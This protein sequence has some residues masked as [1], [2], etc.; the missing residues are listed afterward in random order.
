MYYEK[1][2]E[3]NSRLSFIAG[4]T[5]GIAAGAFL[6]KSSGGTKRLAKAFGDISQTASSIKSDL[7]KLSF[8]ELD[9]KNISRIA[10][11]RV[12]N[13][14][15]TLKMAMRSNTIQDID[16]T[17]GLFAAIRDFDSFKKRSSRIDDKI[18][19]NVL[20]DEVSKIVQREYKNESREFFEQ[21][22]IMA[23]DVLERKQQYFETVEGSYMHAIKEE[24]RQRT[25]GGIFDGQ[26]EKLASIFEEAINNSEEIL[27]GVQHE[28]DTVLHNQLEK[29]YK[30]AILE[31]Y[32]KDTDFFKN[33]LDRAAEV[34]DFLKAVEDGVIENNSEIEEIT[35]ILSELVESDERFGTLKV[36]AKS[37]RISPQNEMYSLKSVNDIA[38][39][40][41]EEV[42]DTIPGKLFGVR[43]HLSNKNVPDFHYFGQGTFDSVLAAHTGSKTGL[44]KNDHFMIGSNVFE[45]SD[46]KLTKLEDVNIKLIGGKHGPMASLI[47]TMA[48]NTY[49]NPVENK[50]LRA[51]DIGTKGELEI[52]EKLSIVKKLNPDSDWIP[53]VVKRLTDD[54]YDNPFYDEKL[55]SGF[56]KDIKLVNKMYN[57]QTFAPDIK[58]ITALKESVE[59]GNVKALLAALESKN[60]SAAILENPNI[61]TDNFINKDLK[62][63][64]NKYKYNKQTID[65]VIHI[66]DMNGSFMGGKNILDY[67]KMITREVF[68]EAMLKEAQIRRN[69]SIGAYSIISSI[70]KDLN[71]S[72]A[73]K[74]NAA[75][76][77]NW[78]ILQ[79]EGDLFASSSHKQI[80]ALKKFEQVD[81][82]NQLLKVKRGN[83]Q[84]QAFLEQFQNGIK[85]FAKENSSAF[86]T[87]Y[88]RNNRPHKPYKSNDFIAINKSTSVLDIIRSLNDEQKLKST[89]KSFGKQLYAGRDNM[90]EVTTAT[91]I[92]FH[93]LNRL[94]TPLE[95]VGLGFSKESTKSVGNLALNIGL[96]RILPV[97]AA[98]YTLSYLNY[99]SENFTGTSLTEAFENVKANFILGTKTITDP[100]SHGN[101][102]SRYYNPIAQYWGGDYKDKDEYLE[103]LEY[104][105]DP[106]RKGRFW[107]FG[108]SAE[109]RG[110]KVA[111]WKPNSLRMAHSNYYDIAVYGSSEE[112][113]KHSLMPSLRHPLS[114]LRF[115][116]NPY[117]LEQKHYEDRPYP[118]TG[119]LFTEGTPWGAVLNPTIGELIKPQRKMHQ[120]EM[121]GTLTDVRTLIAQRNEEIRRKSAE[122]SM[123][124]LDNSGFT[125][126]SFNPNSMPSMS[127]A[128]FSINISDGRV[129]DAG[130]EGQSYANSLSTIDM[131][132]IPIEAAIGAG[133]NGTSYISVGSGDSNTANTA[134]S[135]LG[136]TRL[137][138]LGNST[139]AIST[140]TANDII[141]NVN[142]SIFAKA[143][144]RSGS[145][146]VNEVGNLHTNPFRDAAERQKTSYLE[147]MISNESKSEYVNDLLYSATQL[148]GMYGFLGGQ[149]LPESKKYKL[150]RA[151]MNSFSN[152]FWDSSI[153]GLGDD[154]MEIA[155]RFFPHADHSVEQINNIRNTMPEWM[156][157]RFQLG[158]P[159]N[160]VPLGEARLPGAGY[161]SLNKLHSDK[162]GRYGAFDR[163]KI[164]ADIAPNTEE[165]KTWKKIAKLEVKDPFLVR[166]MEQ[167]EKRVK[168]QTK[169]HD[170]Y[171]YKF[172]TRGLEEHSAII[173]EVTNTGKFTIVGSEQQFS[174]AGIKPLSDKENGSYVHQYL[175]PGMMV[176]LKYED[177]EYRK[178]DKDGNISAL[179]F[180][181]GQNVS[182]QMF[183]D[184]TGKEKSEKETLADEYFALSDS[185]ISMGHFWEA[186]GH[187]PIPYIHNKYLRIDSPMEAYKKEQIYGTPYATWDH[188]IKGFVMPVFQE[189]WGRGIAYQAL[190]L[191]TMVF[192]NMAR[193]KG[194]SDGVQ[195]LAH[196]AF[197]LTNPGGFAGGVIG[198]I[199]RMT[200]SSHASRIGW[201]SKN[202]ANIGAIVGV[203]GYAM[204][205]LENP[206][207]SAGNFAVAGLAA[208]NQLKIDG[209]NGAKG[210]LI[211]AAVGLGLSAI[212]N[213]EFSLNK[214]GEKYIPKDTKKK[215]EIEEYFDRLEYLKYNS[216]YEKAARIAKRKEGVDVAK[217]INSFEYNRD[218]NVDKIRKL[219]ER[220]LKI[221]KTVL[222]VNMRDSLVATLDSQIY[223][224]QTPEQYFQMGE[225]T[226][227]ALAYKK[228]AD[229]TIYGLN[230]YSSTA[231]VLRALPK[232]DRDFFLEFAK[233]KDPKARKKIL[234]YVSPYKQKALKIMWGEDI[235]SNEQ[236]SNYEYFNQHHLPGLSWAG[237]NP[238]VDLD[239]VKMK[240]IENEG[241]L[242]SDFG[243]Y[244]SQK[245]EPAYMYSPEIKDM[246]SPTSTLAIQK[247]LLGL[248]N[249]LGLQNVEVSVD[250]MQGEGFNVIS[251]ITR[252]ASYNLQEKVRTTLE[253]IF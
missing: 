251:N 214:L 65:Q 146:V 240:T 159:Y 112:K 99:E 7:S 204:A 163:Y 82:I 68:K 11:E 34:N 84:E 37:L 21:A 207:L 3:R 218:K 10:K 206:L 71:V 187:M 28:Y 172:L 6:L 9:A 180:S 144:Q 59:N 161:E 248:L 126:M 89:M 100:L 247:D 13:D 118:V 217:I 167:I 227:A 246:N 5:A 115:L 160:K 192:S 62:T 224:L 2:E 54:T 181:D 42:A 117:W 199:P 78:S 136:L 45:Y 122:R 158:D 169:E 171:S 174:L 230:E 53:N 4:A 55:M 128:V 233:E 191:S 15:S 77:L 156:P 127:E 231:D 149:I 51:L 173:E 43:S 86:E 239:N 116:S 194:M 17:K 63:L 60:P 177:N 236:E 49:Y 203:T 252:I 234:K 124:R 152:K 229:T 87:M 166:Q 16:Q 195:T 106:V 176:T 102:A 41:A 107:S 157:S 164:L 108:S 209:I 182:R 205:N 23:T 29:E 142:S 198:A 213:P 113:W 69:E 129:T 183:R 196:T 150:E 193:S 140:G 110:G 222:D 197:A 133:E 73:E 52:K 184:R 243:M 20:I 121:A 31:K 48:G 35:Q 249:G 103:Y 245:G 109:F 154:V 151:N 47:N 226:K 238:Q 22:H 147:S 38:N 92:P 14:D 40:F 220:K 32:S 139:G 221:Q 39:L 123:V 244:E 26:E 201:N 85:T 12:L 119:K 235:A 134:N 25:E 148:S 98:G 241:M 74:K 145:S 190:G 155:R 237:W 46:G 225:Y 165:Y 44:L 212:K 232:Y 67:N 24:F 219:N 175:K 242:L 104:G 215:W 76:L 228:A 111:Y 18:K 141:R 189:A 130:F 36:D 216:L 200:L 81:K 188:P 120:R 30:D 75:N 97:V 64:L 58:T 96:K 131:A 33:T 56:F 1:N 105:Y 90:Q 135:M 179:V 19:D 223:A 138:M 208:A 88:E 61:D 50:A 185:N 137:L 91:L 93:M 210:A 153:G 114:T 170:F 95:G 80:N 79:S 8:K 94:S 83:A 125:P 57:D 101:R 168:E 178:R 211:G 27:N 70:L 162:Y 202:L 186:I 253:N 143:E 72:G 132:S 250:Q 66:G